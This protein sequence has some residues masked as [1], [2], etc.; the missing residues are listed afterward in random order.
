MRRNFLHAS[1]LNL[2]LLAGRRQQGLSIYAACTRSLFRPPKIFPPTLYSSIR[3]FTFT[4]QLGKK[5]K[6]K[7]NKQATTNRPADPKRAV[8]DGSAHSEAANTDPYDFSLLQN[9]IE[10]AI[11]RLK[12]ELGK[13]R[14]G[15]RL[16]PELVEALRVEVKST[17]KDAKDG[18]LMRRLGDLAQV[19]PRGGRNLV[20]IV[21][22]MDVRVLPSIISVE[23][24]CGSHSCFIT[25]STAFELKTNV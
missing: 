25:V 13:L 9:G 8:A 20:V 24:D 17:A 22:E 3:A 10:A 18:K 5:E 7:F 11:T 16:N 23:C 15:G 6:N 4:P 14:A 12:D 2:D 1:F 21:G 19:V